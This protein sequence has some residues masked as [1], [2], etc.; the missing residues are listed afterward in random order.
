[1][2]MVDS[3]AGEMQGTARV[4]DLPVW[5]LY[6][7]RAVYLMMGLFLITG[8]G[9]QL[10]NMPPTLMTGVARALLTGLGLLALLGVRYPVQ[11]LPVMLFEGAWKAVW[12][13]AIGLP[14]WLAG[15][16]DPDSAETFKEC[17]VGLS[18]VLIVLPWK[19]LLSN[20]VRRPSERWR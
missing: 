12:L 11:M 5:R 2:P 8:V 15:R 9:P 6:A 10:A 16:L 14:L 7:L 20:Y 13:A 19:Y 18:L 1:M 17:A 3:Q 4:A